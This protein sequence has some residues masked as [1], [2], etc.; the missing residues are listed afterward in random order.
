MSQVARF[1]DPNLV[2]Q[3]NALQLSAR[4]VT[5]GAISG[6][7]RS[8]VKGASVE[9]RQHRVYVPGD[10]PRRLDW[11]I[12][13]RTDRPYVREHH[14]ETSLRAML[15]LDTSGSMAYER[16]SG[17]KLEY[18]S[19][20]VAALSYLML[21]QT[22][23]VGLAL[24]R[25]KLTDWLSPSAQHSQLPRVINLLE[26]ARG[27]GVGSVDHAMNL[28][29]ERLDR[30]G[31]VVALSDFFVP[32]LRLRAGLARLRHDRHEVIVLQIIDRDEIEFPF[33]SFA[34]FHG[35]ENESPAVCNTALMR[36]TYLDN[37]RSHQADVENT[38]HSMDVEFARFVT[39]SPLTE[40]LITFLTRRT[41]K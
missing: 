18:A 15:L 31:L 38:C 21:G 19:R 39:D 1:L 36:K 6:Q 9:F 30:R 25:E 26:R 16:L 37:F 7:H 23:S 22:E 20:I 11:R 17:T 29:A 10:E 33:R 2:E 34:R 12:L 3:L 13:A 8:R 28:A 32:A 40:S 35:L 24:F 4:T 5:E 41:G 14:E 27:D